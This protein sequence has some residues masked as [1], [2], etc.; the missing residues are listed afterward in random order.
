MKVFALSKYER[1]AE[2]HHLT[3]KLEKLWKTGKTGKSWKILAKNC[4]KSQSP[5][6][7]HCNK[8]VSN[9]LE[10]SKRKKQRCKRNIHIKINFSGKN[11]DMWKIIKTFL[12]ERK[13]KTI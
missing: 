11:I 12:L 4:R 10:C 7:I 2:I 13:M 1:N 3:T 8:Y 5:K 9:D 6:K